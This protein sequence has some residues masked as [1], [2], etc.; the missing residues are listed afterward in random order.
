[1]NRS[2][3]YRVKGSSAYFQQ[4]YGTSNPVFVLEATD[5]EAFGVSWRLTRT[6]A[7]AFNYALRRAADQLPVEGVVYY[8]TITGLG[9]LVHESELEEI[10]E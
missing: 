6:S 1:M 10:T 2:Q 4:K 8:G 3:Q 5:V 7:P 9:E